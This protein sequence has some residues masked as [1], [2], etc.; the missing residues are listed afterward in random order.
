LSRK[1]NRAGT[2]AQSFRTRLSL[3]M[4]SKANNISD[5]SSPF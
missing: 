1:I 2:E 4:F 5:K 3:Y